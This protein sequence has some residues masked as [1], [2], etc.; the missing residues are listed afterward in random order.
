VS[1][2]QTIF[3]IL[4]ALVVA[5]IIVR[6]LR[7]QEPFFDTQDEFEKPEPA[8]RGPSAREL[9][10]D[11]RATELDDRLARKELTEAEHADARAVLA[12]RFDRNEP[13]G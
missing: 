5:F 2:A 6:L 13:L 3:G 9:D 1:P 8:P 11:R 12:T 4:G 10:Y 7:R